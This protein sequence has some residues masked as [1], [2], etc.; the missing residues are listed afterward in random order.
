MPTITT[1]KDLDARTFTIESTFSAP[2]DRIWEL[3]ADPRQLERW[4]GPPT[5]PATVV[6]HDLRPGGRV[7]YFMT[8]PEGEPMHGYW[9]IEAVD[10]P[11]HLSF[12]DGFADE[13]GN[14]NDEMFATTSSVELVEEDGGTRMTVVSTFASREDMEQAMTMGMEEGI[15]SAMAQMDDILAGG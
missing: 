4:W 7:R 13:E 10:P 2:P 12:V 5:Y 6:E 1:D 9:R 15:V 3:W 11:S 14:P 8:S